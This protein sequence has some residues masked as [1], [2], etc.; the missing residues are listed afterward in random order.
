MKYF[1]VK[2][3]KICGGVYYC[4]EISEEQYEAIVPNEAISVN[5]DG[6]NWMAEIQSYC[7]ECC[8]KT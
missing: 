5:F 4:K 8:D 1:Y 7:N 3:C 2:R 6:D